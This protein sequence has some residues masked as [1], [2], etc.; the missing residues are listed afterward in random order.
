MI[1]F[2]RLGIVTLA[3]AVPATNIIAQEDAG[4]QLRILVTNDDG[5][6]AAGLIALVDSLRVVGELVVAAPAEQQSGAGHGITYREPI[7]VTPVDNEQ[8]VTWYA[9]GARPAT[10][11]RLAIT[12]LFERP[13]DLVVSGINSGA[14]IGL[15]A[16]VSGTVAAAREAAFHGIPAI[17]VSRGGNADY[18][19]IAGFIRR[20]VETLETDGLLE[21]GLLLNINAPRGNESGT[22]GVR[23]VPL[24][25]RTGIEVYDRRVSPRGVIYYWDNWRP[26]PPDGSDTDLEALRAG[27]LTITPLEFDQTARAKLEHF[28]ESLRVP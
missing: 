3:I 19:A 20:L 28:R 17:A 10:A 4:R 22:G 25:L 23:V 2:A 11:V 16:W 27:Y 5:A 26:A 13:P 15:D 8:G 7:T 12:S 1:R 18:R 9:I 24:S 14:N 21:P 6:R